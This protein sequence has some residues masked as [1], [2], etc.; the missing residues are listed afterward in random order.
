MVDFPL[1]IGSV[2]K[3]KPI[4]ETSI[5]IATYSRRLPAPLKTTVPAV[6]TFNSMDLSVS[7]DMLQH[8]TQGPNPSDWETSG[9]ERSIELSEVQILFDGSIMGTC[10]HHSSLNR[11]CVNISESR[12]ICQS[13][14]TAGIYGILLERS[15][16]YLLSVT[17]WIH[18]A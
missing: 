1:I 3:L 6:T 11:L 12:F 17:I 5:I 13:N 2:H 8:Q 10:K 9:E 7:V 18:T 4:S 15:C 16:L 14:A